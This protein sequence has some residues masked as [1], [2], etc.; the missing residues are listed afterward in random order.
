M[1]DGPGTGDLPPQPQQTANQTETH[2]PTRLEMAR[3]AKQTQE[4]KPWTE[5]DVTQFREKLIDIGI[6]DEN[7]QNIVQHTVPEDATPFETIESF[8]R[9]HGA[10]TFVDSLNSSNLPP[11][12][13]HYRMNA[14]YEGAFN[15]LVRSDFEASFRPSNPPAQ[16]Q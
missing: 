4:T 10:A 7:P 16:S 13:K 6:I 8:L 12:E 5:D 3:A 2:K 9:S 14:L 1:P 15:G 11:A